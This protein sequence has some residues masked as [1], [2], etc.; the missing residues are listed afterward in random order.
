[1][2]AAG[3]YL[4]Q[5]DNVVRMNIDNEL[6]DVKP[7]VTNVSRPVVPT[8][9]LEGRHLTV[10]PSH[11]R[12]YN[13]TEH[14]WKWQ[15]PQIFGTC[16]DIFTQ[17]FVNPY[18]V[19]M[20]QNAGAVVYMPRERDWQK[21]EVI[22]DNDRGDSG[23]SEEGRW[24][25]AP[26][27]GFSYHDGNYSD[28][29]LPFSSGTAR[30]AYTDAEGDRMVVYKPLIKVSGEHAVYVSYQTVEGS[31]DDAEYTVIH[32]GVKTVFNVNQRMGGSTWVYLGTFDF[33]ADDIENNCVI[34]SNKSKRKRGVVTADAV[35]F[36]GGMGNFQREGLLSYLPRC[37][38]ASRYWVQWAGAP[39]EVSH[40]K[41]GNDDYSED[42]NARSLMSNW[43]S[44][45]SP[46]NPVLPTDTA[47]TDSTANTSTGSGNFLTRHNVTKPDAYTG[48]VPIEMT[49]AVHSDAGWME[50]KVSK[51]GSLTICTTDFD[52]GVLPNGLP[53]TMAKDFAEKL[54]TNVVNDL[55]YRY[56]Y[57]VRH[58]LYDRNYG[59]TRVP[60]QMSV[61]LEMLSHQNFPDMLLGH[62]PDF[63]FWLSRSVYKTILR[64]MAHEHGFEPVV[65]PL[66][67]QRFKV[68]VD[69]RGEAHLSWDAT[70]DTQEPSSKPTSYNVYVGVDS[71]AMSNGTN[72]ATSSCN[73]QLEPHHLY[74][75]RVTAV[76]AGG[77]SFP[78][79][80]LVAAYVPE[81]DEQVLIINAFHRL[82]APMVI[83]TDSLQ[84]F[85]L[86]DDIGLSYG[87]TVAWCGTQK[88]FD[89][90][91]AGD[92]LGYSGN[93][94]MGSF[95]AGNDFNYAA[96]HAA[97][98]LPLRRAT[99][100]SMSS[101][102]IDV[103]D[104]DSLQSAYDMGLLDAYDMV[105]YIAGNEKDDGHSLRPYKSFT[106]RMQDALLRYVDRGGRL[107][108]SGSYIASDMQRDDERAFLDRALHLALDTVDVV[109]SPLTVSRRRSTD[110]NLYFGD[111]T[112]SL[113][114]K[115]NEAHYASH[116]SDVLKPTEKD[117]L[118][119]VLYDSGRCAAVAY[120]DT[121]TASFAL[122]FPFE[123]LRYQHDRDKLMAHIMHF[124]LGDVM[125]KKV[126]VEAPKEQEKTTKKRKR[127]K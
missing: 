68:I 102:A 5:H 40:C 64:H 73:V 59:E 66:A 16:E 115:V 19:P 2:S 99:I 4:A 49:L 109:P 15:R 69:N 127:K 119:P 57:W 91:Y 103:L 60:A 87:K 92:T 96:E 105:D 110:E 111:E 125:M 47:S 8:A 123:C 39:L 13:L 100:S 51:V 55:T 14:I 117:A 70:E 71:Q 122:G 25:D 84:G 43:L 120:K 52:N 104:D 26:R 46:Y 67:P 17:T 31:I 80:E 108:V 22:V 56:G 116:K 93:E 27:P 82:S 90:R 33:A 30:M 21:E 24:H 98:M 81:T 34:L 23:Y 114:R 126:V 20:L 101:E 72:V 62:D 112:M 1:M 76:N 61:I 65:Q 86:N 42:I 6:K 78:T 54:L 53:R 11:G 44:Y 35:R 113:Y 29:E 48:H 12:Y 37:L 3:Q 9:G 7:W 45:G 74:R 79:E 118:M 36:G 89:T 95:F 94:L 106:V 38:E 41:G 77:E 124:L 28:G 75:F 10:W 85:D 58:D 107:F 18:L 50:D 97:S 121:Q 83:D 88:V 32:R 63:K